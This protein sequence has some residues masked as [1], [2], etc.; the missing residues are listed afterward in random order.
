MLS[1]FFI[2]LEE[3]TMAEFQHQPIFEKPKDETKYRK[4]PLEGFR[5]ER[6]GNREV[7]APAPAS[8]ND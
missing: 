3:D 4:L 6:H 8:D 7:L 2:S 5:I 1:S